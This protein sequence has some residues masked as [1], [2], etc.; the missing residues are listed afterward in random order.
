MRK[1]NRIWSVRLAEVLVALCCALLVPVVAQAQDLRLVHGDCTPDLADGGQTR[2]VR[3]GLPK[4]RKDWDASRVYKQMVVLVSFR[5]VDF[6]MEDPNK[7]YNSVFNESGYNK[8]NGVGCVADYF[9][10]Q[11]G[12]R[13][14][15]EFDVFGPIKLDTLANPYTAPTE[16]TRNYGKD[17]FHDAMLEL[18]KQNPDHDFKQYDWDGNGS[19]DQVICVYAG[20]CGN[21]GQGS[22]GHIWPNTGSFTTVTAPDG[23]K[24]ANFSASGELWKN[25]LGSCG[26]GTIC[27]EFSHSLGL[28]DIYPTTNDAGYSVVDEWDLMDGGNFTNYGWCPPDYSPL[29]KMLFG[30][31]TPVEL[32]EPATIK[33]MKTL[34]DGGDVYIIKKT[35][36]NYYL[37][38]NR[39]WQGWSLGVPGRG[40]VIYHVDYLESKWSSNSVNNV[41]GA[42]RYELVHADGLDYDAWDHLLELRDA[43]T[44]YINK[45][46][47]NC[48]YLST[49]PFPWTTD[50][51][52]TVD[53]ALTDTETPITNIRMTDE[54]LVSFD[55]RGG[56]LDAVHDLMTPRAAGDAY[57]DLLGRRVTG[58]PGK[59]IYIVEGKKVIIQ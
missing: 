11:S 43:K 12:G 29:E 35:E 4:V 25:N 49:S 22:Y 46:R 16:K 23:T 42:Y 33:N 8:R 3:R 34:A 15:M 5:D 38:E 28:P 40:L 58:R 19:V 7:T 31:L 47:M 18:L 2:G 54:G 10:D 57:Y 20:L 32:T 30:W 24:I 1:Q 51:T 45:T 39:Q 52:A 9:R 36:D 17:Q 6:Q 53:Q 13:F 48:L 59:G 41:K 14:N 56:D 21:Q 55:F 44:K 27:H 37:L 50:S 26:I